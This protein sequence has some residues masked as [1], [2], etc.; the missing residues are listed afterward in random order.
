MIW[1][2]IVCG[3]YAIVM[4]HVGV[5][6][7]LFLIKHVYSIGV[8]FRE[9][10]RT[11]QRKHITCSEEIRLFLQILLTTSHSLV[12]KPN[13]QDLCIQFWINEHALSITVTR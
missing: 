12:S 13:W 1:L 3:V 9:D 10:Q 11:K 7:L 2:W 6:R 4:S 8:R 5:I